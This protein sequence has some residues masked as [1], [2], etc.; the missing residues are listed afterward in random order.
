M[1]TIAE[2]LGIGELFPA[3]FGPASRRSASGSVAGSAA[4]D[5]SVGDVYSHP[6]RGKRPRRD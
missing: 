6:D 3:A 5:A 4:D 2:D 1:L